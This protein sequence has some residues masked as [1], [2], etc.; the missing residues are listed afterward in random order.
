MKHRRGHLQREF[1][2]YSRAHNG[3]APKP[4]WLLSRSD[5]GLRGGSWAGAPAKPVWKP[6]GKGQRVVMKATFEPEIPPE[7]FMEEYTR[8]NNNYKD[9]MRGIM[10]FLFL[11][12]TEPIIAEEEAFAQIVGM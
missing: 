7:E 1:V 12:Y 2:Q 11:R 6:P 8:V 5:A 3:H 4:V 9:D 10:K